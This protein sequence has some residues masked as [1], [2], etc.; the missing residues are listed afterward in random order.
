MGLAAG[1]HASAVLERSSSGLAA[2]VRAV[3]GGARSRADRLG[4]GP[5]E[6]PAHSGESGVRMA[7]QAIAGSSTV[8]D[9]G[10]W[11]I[12]RVG[13][14]RGRLTTRT[15]HPE[16]SKS[17]RPFALIRMAAA[18]AICRDPHDRSWSRGFE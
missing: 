10:G 8:R 12:E 4:R 15:P 6:R 7:E 3:A 1:A 13:D 2:D 17:A 14:A 11:L 5:P 18:G 16:T 9:G